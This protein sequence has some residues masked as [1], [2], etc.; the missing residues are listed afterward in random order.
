[1]C[2]AALTAAPVAP[3]EAVSGVEVSDYRLEVTWTWDG[4]RTR[5]EW[6]P[7]RV[8]LVE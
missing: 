5:V 2:L 3:A 7:L 8:S 6:E 4:A 1:V